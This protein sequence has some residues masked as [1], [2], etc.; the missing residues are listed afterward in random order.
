MQHHFFPIVWGI[1]FPLLVF[2]YLRK[3]EK[4]LKQVKVESCTDETCENN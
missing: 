4:I 3:E 1:N 2:L